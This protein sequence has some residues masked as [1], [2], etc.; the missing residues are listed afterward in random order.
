MGEDVKQF[1]GEHIDIPKPLTQEQVASY[2]R[3]GRTRPAQDSRQLRRARLR[4]LW[5]QIP[6]PYKVEE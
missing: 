3:D 6:W 1:A 4:G 2:V 5:S